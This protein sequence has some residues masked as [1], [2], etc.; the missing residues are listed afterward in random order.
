MPVLFREL[1]QRNKVTILVF[2]DIDEQTADQAFAYFSKHYNVIGLKDFLDARK[3]GQPLPPK[4]LILT[5]DDGHIRNYEL[6]SAFKKYGTPVTIFLCAG[7]VGTNRHYWF[8][9][10]KNS[11]RTADLKKLP[12]HERLDVLENMGFQQEK[13]F[14]K[15]QALTYEQISEMKRFV[16]FQAHTL[17]HPILPKCQDAKAEEEI[18]QSKSV[19][20]KKFNLK[21]NAIAYPN[22]DYSWRDIELAKRAGYECG[23]TVDF[24]FNT[25]ETDPF[26]LKR[27]SVNDTTK[28]DELIVKA[29]GVW[30]F[31]KTLGGKM[32]QGLHF[33]FCTAIPSLLPEYYELCFLIP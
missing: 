7:I 13:E 19:L 31:F 29:T 2:H 24:G 27:L 22:G 28:M 5:F 1:V 21:V 17:F 25:T 18:L 11:Y 6:L 32:K 33:W 9:A 23:L 10:K 26:R 15:P 12:N 16:N 8:K 4:A 3:H 20:E 14:D 30:G